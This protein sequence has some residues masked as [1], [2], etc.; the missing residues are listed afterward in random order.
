[1]PLYPKFYLSQ[2]ASYIQLTSESLGLTSQGVSSSVLEIQDTSI[3]I[4]LVNILQYF[5][6]PTP[7]LLS[8]RTPN[9]GA[10]H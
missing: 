3:G 7:K 8:L 2:K 10:T 9:L 5:S 6:S 1:M 4:L